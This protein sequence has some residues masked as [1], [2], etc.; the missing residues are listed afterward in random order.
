MSSEATVEDVF[1][2]AIEAERAAERL[3]QGLAA[4]FAHHA[5]VAR[6]WEEYASEEAVH[7]S[8][9][10][11]LRQDIAAEKLSGPVTRDVLEQA[12]RA[13]QIDVER[14]LEGVADLQD[15]YELAHETENSETNSVFEFLMTRFAES[16]GA[17][18]F[19]RMQLRDHV[20]RITMGFPEPYSDVETRRAIEA[21]E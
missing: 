2:L 1:Q 5:D 19:V 12:R 13:S 3:Y 14:A 11:E 18:D 6:F 4:K 9:L 10:E 17:Q 8:K 21:K 16:E 7:A 15:A 20:G